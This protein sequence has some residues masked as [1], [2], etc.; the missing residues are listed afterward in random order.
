MGIILTRE[1]RL[2]ALL[3]EGSEERLHDVLA[4]HIADRKD[5]GVSYYYL[6]LDDSQ[7]SSCGDDLS[8]IVQTLKT[9]DS[10][11]RIRYLFILGNEEVI[12]V[13]V[14]EDRTDDDDFVESDFAF[15]SLDESSPWE[16]GGF[17]LEKALRVGRLPI[18]EG[19]DFDYF[20]GYF[21]AVFSVDE[22]LDPRKSYGLSALVWEDESN[23]EYKCFAGDDVDV[24]PDVTSE[25]VADRFDRNTN[26]FFF[27]LHGSNETEYWYG[28]E[29][30]AY[31]EAASP[32]MF[33]SVNEPF[34]L[35]V[36]ACYGAKYTDGLTEDD[37]MLLRAMTHGCLC[38]VG[39]S[40]IAYG[41][42]EPPGCCADVV[43]GEFMKSILSG[44]TAGD[45]FLSGIDKM[46]ADGGGLD[47]AEAKTVAEF[48]LY[49]DPS[50]RAV[51]G[52]SAAKS[53]S[54]VFAKTQFDRI[55]ID[56]PDIRRPINLALADVNEKIEKIIDEFARKRFFGDL[57]AE[58][59]ANVRQKVLRLP[60]LHLNQKMFSRKLDKFSQVV[61]IYFDDFGK[62]RR[63][64][65]SK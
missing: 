13:A 19:E 61:K 43:I 40:R 51:A 44:K 34:V 45:A 63:V 64:Y 50:F 3:S 18:Y 16:K 57:G 2:L 22:K 25:N 36:E 11:A 28:Q 60:D 24:S 49:G 9:I 39:S 37:S 14:W 53:V 65:E 10:V 4:N 20:V 7:F 6:D 42:S 48:G 21:D 12:D 52:R 31:P 55:R 56:L 35:A 1:S 27:N 8:S 15:T 23:D 26:F 5:H 54:G 29:G 62:I 33:W 41:S 17:D 38:F 59:M 47:D 32:D 30:S 46:F 58:E